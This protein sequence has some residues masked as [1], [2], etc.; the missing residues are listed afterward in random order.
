MPEI[1][2]YNQLRNHAQDGDLLFLT[3]NK[4]DILSR[5]TGL[6]TGSK[7]SHAAFLFWYRD[8]LMVVES[9]THG[10]IRIVTASQYKDRMMTLIPAPKSWN[11][12]QSQVLEKSGTAEYGWFSAAYI[13]IREFMF[14][15][16]N[17]SLP[18]NRSNRNLACSEFV[19]ENLG[20]AESD[21][22]PELLLKTLTKV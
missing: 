4:K 1:L 18:E 21:I 16:F 3:I 19:A 11:E 13:G 8:R 7:Y 9:T 6:V 14:N 2:S 5:L 22:S 12:I 20:L 17:F 10:G 15:H